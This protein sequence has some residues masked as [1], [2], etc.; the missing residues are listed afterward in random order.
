MMRRLLGF[1]IVFLLAAAGGGALFAR[2]V[3]AVRSQVQAHAQTQS[4][5]LGVAEGQ[6]HSDAQAQ[7]QGDAQGAAQAQGDAAA[8][9]P[10]GQPP[11]SA[12]EFAF[13]GA[14]ACK[15]CHKSTAKGDQFGKWQASPHAQ[16]YS[17]LL[18]EHAAQI[19]HV[20]GTRESPTTVARCL[21]CHVTGA[22]VKP[23]LLG[24]KWDKTEGVGCESCHGPAA[25]WKAIHLKD[26]DK[27]MTLGMIAPDENLCRGCHN[28]ESP[29]FKGFDFEKASAQIA[30]PR[31]RKAAKEE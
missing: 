1:G 9:T 7:A 27:A 26:V 25:E 3:H 19:A 14:Q 4:E 6:S 2:G 23:E 30:H 20:M 18:T 24:P 8:Q 17:T 15:G 31:L 29:T 12:K 11:K 10:K 28:P 13:I 5:S 22:G 16:A 21:K